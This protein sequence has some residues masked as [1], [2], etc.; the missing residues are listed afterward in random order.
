MVASV[1]RGVQRTKGCAFLRSVEPIS[2]CAECLAGRRN[3]DPVNG[4]GADWELLKVDVSCIRILQACFFQHLAK[5]TDHVE[6]ALSPTSSVMII[7]FMGFLD[8]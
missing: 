1:D 2:D 7:L 6:E 4:V 8:I 3:A 5:F